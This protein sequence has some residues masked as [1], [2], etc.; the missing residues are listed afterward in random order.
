MSYTVLARKHRSRS[1]AEIVGQEA[2]VTT[3][4]NAITGDRVHHGYLFC[5]TRGVGKTS[6]ARILAKSLNCLQ[7]EGPTAEPCLECDSCIAVGEGEDIDVIEIDAASNTGVD[8]IRDLR[9]AAHYRPARSRFK[10]Y[11]IDEVHMLSTGAFNALLKILEEPPEH[12]KFILATTEQ[13]KV[14][15]TIQSRVQRF[16]FQSISPADIAGQLAH[17]LQGESIQAEP[18]ALRRVARLAAGS[19]RD[20]L[21]LLDQVLSCG[22][23]HVT[24][25]TIRLVLPEAH[26]EVLAELVDAV[27]RE[28][29]GEALHVLDRYLCGG[30]T[31]E[32]FCENLSTQLRTLMIAKLCG[33]GSELVDVSEQTAPRIAAQIESFAA[34]DFAHM[35]AILEGLRRQIRTSGAGRALAD[36]AVVR[37]AST[38]GVSR[39]EEVLDAVGPT[40]ANRPKKKEYEARQPE[41]RPL[42]SGPAV[43]RPQLADLPESPTVEVPSAKP[44]YSEPLVPAPVQHGVS[45]EEMNNA[46]MDPLVREALERFEGTLMNVERPAQAPP[47]EPAG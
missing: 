41:P 45:S 26:D 42:E 16:E 36:A 18:E 2:I 22:A 5:G 44:V 32:Q 10:I 24:L 7:S 15:A 25:E 43:A 40:A 13:H 3:L 29:P 14:P 46:R 30:H 9:D 39:I 34:I 4:R 17:V 23:D 47:R 27:A 38:P 21:S 28:D 20:A 31:C 35:I 11:I 8:H 37:L 1:L 12:V 19:M 6:T 33:T